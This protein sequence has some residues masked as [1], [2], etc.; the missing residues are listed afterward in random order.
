MGV[1]DTLCNM[2][3]STARIHRYINDLEDLYDILKLR[4]F[5]IPSKSKY[6]LKKLKKLILNYI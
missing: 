3:N 4:K 1:Y 6:G 5:K 2:W